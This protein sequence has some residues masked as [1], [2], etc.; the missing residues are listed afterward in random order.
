MNV[1]YYETLPDYMPVDELAR[2]CER[3]LCEA[4]EPGVHPEAVLEGL[5]HLVDRQHHAYERPCQEGDEC[6]VNAVT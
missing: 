4:D 2:C 5:W 3:L 6:K 1:E